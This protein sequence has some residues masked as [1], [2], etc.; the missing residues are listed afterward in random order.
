MRKNHLATKSCNELHVLVSIITVF[1]GTMFLPVL[2]RERMD[3]KENSSEGQIIILLHYQLFPLSLLFV[4][5]SH[6]D[7][8]YND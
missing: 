8:S 7:Y 4:Q 2:Q 3:Q 6:L 1:S 5:E